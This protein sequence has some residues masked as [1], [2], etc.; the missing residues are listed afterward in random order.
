MHNLAGGPKRRSS[1]KLLLSLTRPATPQ[2]SGWAMR[3]LSVPWQRWGPTS[4]LCMWSA[5]FLGGRQ[6]HSEARSRSFLGATLSWETT[7]GVSSNCAPQRSCS[8]LAVR[9]L[10]TT[11]QTALPRGG[12]AAEGGS[13]CF[14]R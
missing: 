11:Q 4:V 12:D 14:L 2:R 8:L 9:A 10:L 7:Q 13:A 3:S 5:A 1:S 6:L